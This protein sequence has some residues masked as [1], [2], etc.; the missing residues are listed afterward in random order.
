MNSFATFFDYYPRASK[1]HLIVKIQYLETA[2]AVFGNTK[3]DLISE[4]TR[5]LGP[6]IGNH[7]YK[8]KYV[9]ELVTNLNSH[10]RLLSKIAETE[11]QSAYAAFV[12]GFKRKLTYLIVPFPILVNYYFH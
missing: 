10:L 8:E 12:N 5:H 11:P 9:N 6:V 7:P 1:S 4:S 2:N 3:I